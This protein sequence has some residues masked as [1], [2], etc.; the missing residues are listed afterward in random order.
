MKKAFIIFFIFLPLF[1]YNQT[2]T[3]HHPIPWALNHQYMWG[4]Q[5]SSWNLN[6]NQ[7][8]FHF[9]INENQSFGYIEDL[10]TLGQ[11][12]IDLNLNAYLDIALSYYASGF[13]NGWVDINYPVDITLTFPDYGTIIPG[14]W[15]TISSDY[16]VL[17][18][19]Y[20]HPTFPDEGVIGMDFNFGANIN[21]G[22][23]L[24]AYNCTSYNVFNINVPYDSVILL[25]L[26]TYTGIATYPCISG[27]YPDICYS[28]VIPLEVNDI[29][30][31]GLALWADIPYISSYEDTVL[32]NK[33]LKA[34][35]VDYY[36]NL[37]LNLIQ[38]IESM[39]DIIGGSTGDAIYNF[40][41][42]LSGS[43]QIYND[44]DMTIELNYTLIDQANLFTKHY[45][46]QDLTF[47]PTIYTTF[48]FPT[49]VEYKE[50]DTNNNVIQSGINDTVTFIV[51][52]N[53]NIL[54]PC[55]GL[56]SLSTG[57][58]LHFMK[59]Q[60]NNHVWDSIDLNF[61][62]IGLSFTLNLD[63]NVSKEAMVNV[64]PLCVEISANEI[65]NIENNINNLK[66]AK[67]HYNFHF[68]PF[69]DDT[70]HITDFALTW[71]NDTWEILGFND[72]IFQ[73]EL[74][75][76]APSI[77]LNIIGDTILCQGMQ[78]GIIYAQVQNGSPP[79][80]FLWSTG[81]NNITNTPIDSI[82]VGE[83]TYSVTITDAGGCSVSDG[84]NIFSNPPINISLDKIDVWCKH[85][86][87]G[88][89]MIIA[90]GGTPP[91]SYVL[92]PNNISSTTNIF[93]SLPKGSYIVE[94]ID[95]YGCVAYDTIYLVELYELPPVN[96]MA[97]PTIGCQPL[98]VQFYETNYE[99]FPTNRYLWSFGDTIY[100]PLHKFNTA[101][102]I[103]IWVQVT[104]EF[105]CDTTAYYSQFITVYPSPQA[106]MI[107]DPVL[108]Y[109]TDDPTFTIQC[110]NQS[111]GDT[112]ISWDFGDSTTS[113]DDFP[114]HSY[115]NDG[116]YTVTLIAYN[117]YG[118]SDTISRAVLMI[119]DVL[120]IPNVITP[121]GDGIND[122]FI[123]EN[124]DKYPYSTLTILNRW[125]NVVY[126]INGYDNTWDAKDQPGGTYYYI[127]YTGSGPNN[128]DKVY[129]G[130]ITIIK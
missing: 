22:G 41:N 28:N 34:S 117:E 124:I 64:P 69:L 43:I 92:H 47:C 3:V 101:G 102:N 67:S 80:N 121:N 112:Y 45:L 11:W 88:T 2:Y 12:G 87:T 61:N 94:I 40:I 33:C 4:P 23:Q 26:N 56:D 15:A 77:G 91:Y 86:S 37:T 5:G 125:G 8:I 109:A 99:Y 90:S 42:S 60:F 17:P 13:H 44:P 114:S 18:N 103:D 1:I 9:N 126:E 25:E 115:Q 93:D 38:F 59:N 78:N 14:Q 83:G 65:V 57:P 79:Y 6:L 32:S 128:P 73:A 21:L 96:I 119:D 35:G 107:I 97:E 52:N 29:G 66:D 62:I 10:G 68:G 84:I 100:N 123:I 55:F 58:I 76:S 75:S 116:T 36:M 127:L 95:S 98:Y 50:I 85:D 30:G 53:L 49:P 120:Q 74:L 106:N 82:I 63:I 7:D 130:T 129:N 39:A 46:H 16:N 108:V 31:I 113:T 51:G 122:A 19:A 54:W 110:Y 111:L 20:L 27:G 89:I 70:L 48:Y 24:C 81:N 72:S 105:G 71:M 104:N 118:C